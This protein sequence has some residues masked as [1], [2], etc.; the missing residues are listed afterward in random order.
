MPSDLV[1]VYDKMIKIL[2]A[3]PTKKSRN[4]LQSALRG[5][6]LKFYNII[7]KHKL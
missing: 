5:L 4:D 3:E 6:Y 2:L 7:R 1:T